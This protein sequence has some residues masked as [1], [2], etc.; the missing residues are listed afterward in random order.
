M[1][2]LTNWPNPYYYLTNFVFK[3]DEK[4]SFCLNF[5]INFNVY[6]YLDFRAVLFLFRCVKTIFVLFVFNIQRINQKGKKY[7][8]FP[9]SFFESIFKQDFQYR[10]VAVFAFV[11]L[12]CYF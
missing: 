3:A 11:F 4:I 8:Y 1:N 6:N 12:H 9:M 2:F 5:Q 7:K 10:L